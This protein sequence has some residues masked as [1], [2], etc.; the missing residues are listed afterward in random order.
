[1]HGKAHKHTHNCFN[2]SVSL[3]LAWP[4]LQ[5]VLTRTHAHPHAQS[6]SINKTAQNTARSPHAENDN[7]IH[8]T[9]TQPQVL[10]TLFQNLKTTARARARTRIK[11][12]SCQHVS[13]KHTNTQTSA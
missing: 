10:Y 4:Q 12:T 2:L 1:M 8:T 11:K 7:S 3:S 9:H 5:R 13:T 6:H